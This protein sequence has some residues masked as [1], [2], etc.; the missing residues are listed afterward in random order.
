MVP[1][2]QG[3]ASMT[4]AVEAMEVSILERKLIHDGNP[5]LTWNVSNAMALSDAA[6]NRKLD[7]SA[8]RFRI[9]GA[10]A[11]SM[12]IGLKSRDRKEQPEPSAYE[13]LSKDEILKTMRF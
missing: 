4:Q 1:W 3:Y 12:A 7:K 9:D 6:G 5:C 2:G 11:L 13:G 10:V 8:S